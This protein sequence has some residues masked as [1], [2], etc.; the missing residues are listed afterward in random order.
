M[1][2]LATRRLTHTMPHGLHYFMQFSLQEPNASV[3]LTGRLNSTLRFSVSRHI[4]QASLN[5]DRGRQR[6]SFM[7]PECQFPGPAN[8][9]L[10]SSSVTDR[11]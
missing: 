6:I 2:T 8:D 5:S 1:P 3:L 9:Q 4:F 10:T 11:K 7:S